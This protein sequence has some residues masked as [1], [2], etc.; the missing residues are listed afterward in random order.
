MGDCSGFWPTGAV[1]RAVQ[2]AY[3]VHA[4]TTEYSAQSAEHHLQRACC[5]CKIH[6]P[7]VTP[8]RAMG[9]LSDSAGQTNLISLALLTIETSSFPSTA[10]YD[11]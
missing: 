3:C 5:T 11:P 6:K 2:S 7:P 4:N 8:A 9:G 10:P 1:N